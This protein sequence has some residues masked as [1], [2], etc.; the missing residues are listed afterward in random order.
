MSDEIIYKAQT[1]ELR[2][3]VP[4]PLMIAGGGI[5]LLIAVTV[6]GVSIGSLIGAA[7]VGGFGLLLMLPAWKST[8]DHRSKASFLAA[9]GAFLAMLGVLQFLAALFQHEE[10]WTY[11]WLLL[12]AAV[13]G[14]IMYA[15]R[16]DRKARVHVWGESI[17]RILVALTLAFGLFLE[18]LVYRTFGPLW[19]FMVIGLGV[20]LFIRHLRSKA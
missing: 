18:L 12:P 8:E 16:F 17:L 9:P 2:K 7:M 14:G 3:R 13:I 5:L 11:G 15:K 19:P 20:Y 1:S 4:A 6:F 10:I